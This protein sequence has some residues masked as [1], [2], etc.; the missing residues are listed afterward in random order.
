MAAVAGKTNIA[1]DVSTPIAIWAVEKE[2]HGVSMFK[3]IFV[4]CSMLRICCAVFGRE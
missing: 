2:L 4:V 3:A 1:A